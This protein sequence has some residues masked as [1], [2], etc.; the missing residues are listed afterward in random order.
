MNDNIQIEFINQHHRFF[1]DV[2]NLGN[3]HSS[4]LGFMPDG[5]FID[6]A[7]KRCIIIAHNNIELIGYLMFRVVH[8]SS[9]ISIAHLCVKENFRGQ[10]IPTKLLDFLRKKYENTFAG[11]SINCREDYHN[12]TA[13]WDKYGFVN[14]GKKRS[15]SI[16]ENY[17]CKW[18]Y[19]F[20]NTDLFSITQEATPKIKA[21]L[22]TNIIIKLRDDKIAQNPTQDPRALLADWLFEEVDYFYAPEIF[23]EIA[24]DKNREREDKTRKFLENFEPVRVNI[25][26]CKKIETELISIIS[27]NTENDKSDR[28]QLATAIVSETLYFITFDIGILDKKEFI[29]EQYDIQIFT[30]Q[31]FIIEIDQLQNKAEYSPA[32]L[33]GVTF[34][35]I[36]KVSNSELDSYIDLFLDKSQSEK[37]TDFKNIVYEVASQIRLYKIKVI[38]QENNPLAFFSYKYENTTLTISFIRLLDT[39]QKQTLFM[40]LIS[41][42]INKAITKNFS[43]IKIE[44]KHLSDNQKSILERL[45]FDY[46]SLIWTK[47]LYDKVITSSQLSELNCSNISFEMLQDKNADDTQ[48]ILLSLEH[49]FF[50]L[51]FSDLDIPCYI[52]PIKPYWAGQL[53]DTY[54]SG[55]DLFGA[56]PDKLWNIENVYYRSVKPITEIAPARILWYVSDDKTSSK[57]SKFHSRYK[58]IVATSYLD[59]VMTDK[60]KLLFKR[61]K[62]YGI[63]EWNNIYE[64]CNEDV[65]NNIR[66][67]RFSN[68]EIFINP[69]K[70]SEIHQVFIDNGRKTNTFASPVKVDKNIFTQIYLLRNGKNK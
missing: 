58:S 18:W 41:D 36:E 52:I 26:N 24:R 65:E 44:E 29:E 64:L 39:E 5:G 40:Q 30:P 42:F 51:K 70:L 63:Y 7:K 10:Q 31:E 11:I 48:N 17:L 14:K 68:T 61:Y 55:S 53:F 57:K 27:G 8:R 34:H 15:R 22:D 32:K 28:R 1:Q 6:H 2:I 56:Q 47:S 54:I 38:K 33:K 62:H 60:P 9:R 59:E 4:T 69:V 67:L 3:K 13:L 20:G 37:K 21:L 49:K 50:P 35:Y 16:E 12:A 45:G 25:E 46:Q 23:N 43:Q 66:L 19:D